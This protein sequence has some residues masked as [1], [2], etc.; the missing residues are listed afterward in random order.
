MKLIPFLDGYFA[1]K[2]GRIYSERSNKFMT[3]SFSSKNYHLVC[4]RENGKS[5][6][7]KVH[8]L[9]ASTYLPNPENKP[10]VN[11]KN[12]IKTDNRVENLEW[13]TQS[14]NQIHAHK[15]G[16]KDN[17]VKNFV[18][19]S[20]LSNSRLVLDLESGIFFDSVVEAANS[21]S[22]NQN[23]LIGYLGGFRKNKT[24]LIYA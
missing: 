23:T 4:I 21:K 5:I 13:C 3:P 15:T 16:L 1:Y 10:Q 11:H 6:T 12:G 24:S 19:K 14:E 8:R 22:I 2:D 18:N 7:K 17:F 9:I 20:R